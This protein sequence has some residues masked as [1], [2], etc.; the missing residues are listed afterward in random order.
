MVDLQ[1]I[2]AIKRLKYKYMRCIDEKRW[3]E[4]AEILDKVERLGAE[5]ERAEGLLAA[6]GLVNRRW[7]YGYRLLD[8]QTL[9]HTLFPIFREAGAPVE[10][11]DFWK[12][13]VEARANLT[14]LVKE[15]GTGT[16][17]RIWQE[18]FLALFRGCGV[19]EDEI[20]GVGYQYAG[21][22]EM[23]DRYD[24]EKLVDGWNTVADE[25]L[26]FIRNPALG[27]WAYW[28]RLPD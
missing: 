7:P 16:E 22:G 12:A 24:P 19:P 4:L 15:G 3:D 18:Y 8:M 1:E 26:F 9:T 13:E 6:Y 10:E 2:E 25:R 20:E 27:L 14:H 21:L 11:E 17:P 28:G 23:M 5:P